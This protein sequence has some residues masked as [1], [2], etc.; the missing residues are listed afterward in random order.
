MMQRRRGRRTFTTGSRVCWTS[1]DLKK[2]PRKNGC[3]YEY[4][5]GKH[6]LVRMDENRE[7]L[8]DFCASN[9]M[10]IG[11]SIFPH[12]TSMRSLGGFLTMSSKTR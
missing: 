12:R 2:K 3:R 5:M 1:K 8:A 11:G 4:V 10:V 9:N 6:G 7:L